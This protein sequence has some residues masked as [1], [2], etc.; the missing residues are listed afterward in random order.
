[1][2]GLEVDG[3]GAGYNGIVDNTSGSLTVTNC[4]LENFIQINQNVTTGNGI[5]MQ[6]TSGT[7][8]FTITNTTALNNGNAGVLY[9]PPSGS[10]NAKGV[11]D[12]VVATADAYGISINLALA[13]G[14][15]TV[16]GISNSI[17]SNNSEA[18]VEIATTSAS[19]KASI[20]NLWASGN[21][22]GVEAYNSVNVLLGRSVITSNATGVFNGTS[23]GNT[24]YS[25]GNNQINLNGV[26]DVPNDIN[27]SPNS[28][29]NTSTTQ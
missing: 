23:P 14:G 2:I 28:S 1:L 27:G 25:Y 3:A 24:F 20:D 7:L 5:L 15:T 29:L 22:T 26:D 18:G 6:P 21:L 16:A 8:D 11:I 13:S 9:Y 10:P 12:H 19:V 4:T 17:T